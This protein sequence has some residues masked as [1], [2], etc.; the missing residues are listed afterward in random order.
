MSSHQSYTI[1]AD[2][3]E[4]GDDLVAHSSA[5]LHTHTTGQSEGLLPL[6][7]TTPNSNKG[8]GRAASVSPDP[9]ALSG[10]I[11]SSPGGVGERTTRSTVGGVKTETRYTGQD[12]LDEPVSETIMRDLRAIGT[13]IVQVLHP[14]SENAVLKDWDLWGPLMFCLSLAILLS[15]N[16]PSEQS[17]AIFTGVFVIVWLGSVV[18]TL[19]AKLLGGKVSF[20]QSLCVLGY[21]VFPIDI[22]AIVSVFIKVLWIRLPICLAA[23]GWS[24]WAA[25]NFL[26]GTRLEKD[27]AVLAIYPLVLLFFLLA[28]MVMLS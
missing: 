15:T 28:W 17:L 10:R 2:S 3:D 26:G 20:F 16:A 4:E 21:C 14:T 11:G 5:N 7:A 9:N 1:A 25:V 19:N 23:F 8:K 24:I 12:T 6:P 13:K 27:R 22:A 18:V